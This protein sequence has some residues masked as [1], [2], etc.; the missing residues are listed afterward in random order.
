[1][2]ASGWCCFGALARLW[3]G[4]EGG[5]VE[6]SKLVL[7]PNVSGEL[8]PA[9]TLRYA[10]SAAGGA[11]PCLAARNQSKAPRAQFV[12]ALPACGPS[13]SV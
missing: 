6:V 9:Q 10:E 7:E 5:A 3:R 4:G 12:F 2:T 11:L 1:M 13:D 8:V